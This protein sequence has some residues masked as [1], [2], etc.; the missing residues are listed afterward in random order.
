MKPACLCLLKCLL[1][2][3][4]CNAVNFD[5]HLQGGNAP[6]RPGYLKIHV[7]IMVFI[8]NNIG[9]NGYI[10]SVGN[11]THGHACHRVLYG[12]TCIHKREA[13]AADRRHG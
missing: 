3:L 9:Q 12:H 10:A 8:T 5:I 11:K 1:N 13:S 6:T 7:P 4:P 2:Y